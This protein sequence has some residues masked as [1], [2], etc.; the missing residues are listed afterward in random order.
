MCRALLSSRSS[1]E[2]V[3]SADKGFLQPVAI[4]AVSGPGGI[5]AAQEQIIDAAEM[6]L[7]AV[8]GQ[9]AAG[10]KQRARVTKGP[11]VAGGGRGQAEVVVGRGM[12]AC[13][14]KGIGRG[15]VLAGR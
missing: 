2:V 12:I 1:Q 8:A 15:V 11:V 3:E 14:L 7:V 4:Y 9:A 10:R 5:D 6:L 13:V